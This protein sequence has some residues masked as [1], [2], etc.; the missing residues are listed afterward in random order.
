MINAAPDGTATAEC[1]LSPARLNAGSAAAGTVRRFDVYHKTPIIYRLL[2]I[3][4]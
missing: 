3:E 2:D 4:A 1:T